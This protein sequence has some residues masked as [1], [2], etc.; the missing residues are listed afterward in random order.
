M[1]AGRGGR[2]RGAGDALV[3]GR[4]QA[5]VT[6]DDEILD[7]P[8]LPLVDD[9]SLLELAAR[10]QPAGNGARALALLRGGVHFDA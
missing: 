8:L 2:R 6:A 7:D 4:L 10:P 5:V 9:A 1:S 3:E